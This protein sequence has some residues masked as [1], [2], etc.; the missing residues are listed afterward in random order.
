[1]WKIVPGAAIGTVV[2]TDRSPLPV[3]EIRAPSP[4]RLPSQSIFVCAK[5]LN[6]DVGPGASEAFPPMKVVRTSGTGSVAG[7]PQ[8]SVADPLLPF[9]LPSASRTR[10][11][12]YEVLS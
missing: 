10:V 3:A 7:K 8:V 4:P 2:L 12:G 5:P 9:T 1:M 6:V 11:R